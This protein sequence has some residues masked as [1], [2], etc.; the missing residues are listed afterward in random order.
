MSSAIGPFEGAVA[1]TADD[2]AKDSSWRVRLTEPE[3]DELRSAAR[4]ALATGKPITDLACTEFPLPTLGDKLTGF[5]DDLEGGRGFVLLQGLPVE[6]FTDAEVPVLLWGVGQYLGYPEPQD[7]AGALLHIVTD[8]GAEVD[9][10]DNIRGFQTNEEL[11]FHTDGAD[12][13]ALM[14]LRPAKSGG[15]SRLVSSVAIYNAILAERP[16]LAAE[17]RAP[18]HFDTRAQNP[19]EA[20][21][22]TLPVFTPHDGLLSAL[23][24]RR[25]IETAQ[26]FPELPRL[27][28]KQIEALDYLDKTAN[29]PR[30]HL[31]LTLAPGDLEIGNNATCFHARDTYTDHD[32]LAAR[33][34]ML[35]LWLTLP[36]GRPLPKIY[37]STR[38]WGPTYRRRMLQQSA[39]E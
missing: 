33:R 6:D 23:Y 8:T 26:R 5:R 12:I 37:E 34:C 19:N 25:Y 18:F 35:R 17:L 22:Q 7:K 21:I 20:K 2:L 28:A 30:F 38:E 4:N 32:D 29:D 9:K 39:A 13:F 11:S 31:A 36:N 16:D 15:R 27:I 1:W 3:R 14:C 24:K 10:T